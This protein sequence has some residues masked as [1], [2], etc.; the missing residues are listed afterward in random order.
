[1]LTF[2][3]IDVDTKFNIVVIVYCLLTPV[4]LSF[5]ILKRDATPI[6]CE[7]RLAGWRPQHVTLAAGCK[8]NEGTQKLSLSLVWFFFSLWNIDKLMEWIF[9]IR[10]FLNIWIWIFWSLKKIVLNYWL[11]ILKEI[12][13]SGTSHNLS[14][15]NLR[16]LKFDPTPIRKLVLYNLWW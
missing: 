14:R 4:V 6:F 15:S 3:R 10:V 2:G 11:K 13:K 1:M 7:P 12:C 5:L 8:K 16:L 9:L